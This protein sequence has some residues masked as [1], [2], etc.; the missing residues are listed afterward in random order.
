MTTASERTRNLLQAGAFLKRLQH[1]DGLP[2]WVRAEAQR[3][4]RHYPTVGDVSLL[5]HFEARKLGTDI[6]TPHIE[7]TWLSQYQPGGTRGLKALGR[8]CQQKT[9]AHPRNG[10]GA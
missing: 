8:V 9:K 4:L 1:E 6:L 3:L 2:E 10:K 7:P 5:A